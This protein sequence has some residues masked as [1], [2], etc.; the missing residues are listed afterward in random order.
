MPEFRQLKNLFVNRLFVYIEALRTQ[1][2]VLIT[3]TIN[4]SFS[5]A[6]GAIFFPS[7]TPSLKVLSFGFFE[8]RSPKRILLDLAASNCH[9]IGISTGFQFIPADFFQEFRGSKSIKSFQ[10][11]RISQVDGKG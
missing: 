5:V 9:I 3:A 2:Q 7:K 11:R 1:K 6:S 4:S 8:Y 10:L